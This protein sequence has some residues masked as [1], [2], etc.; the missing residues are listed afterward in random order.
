MSNDKVSNTLMIKV[1]KDRELQLDAEIYEL[2]CQMLE[3]L[4]YQNIREE[5]L[6]F[7]Q[8][9]ILNANSSLEELKVLY[10]GLTP[11]QQEQVHEVS[12]RLRVVR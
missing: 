8:L 6:N 7:Q 1:L 3:M 10:D 2:N 5:G 4:G 9:E 11:E 12:N